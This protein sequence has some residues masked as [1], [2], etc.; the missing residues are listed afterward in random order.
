MTFE[1]PRIAAAVDQVVRE[2]PVGTQV[3]RD[4][5]RECVGMNHDDGPSSRGIQSRLNRKAHGRAGASRGS[6]L[7]HKI[8]QRL[9][10]LEK[11]GA[12][13]R[14][15]ETHIMVLDHTLMPHLPSREDDGLR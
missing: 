7:S 1:W 4:Y 10:L 6:I 3:S 11:Y 13:V 8:K 5:I 9:V 14:V 2:T 15:G 12:I